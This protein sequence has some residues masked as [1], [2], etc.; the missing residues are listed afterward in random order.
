VNME[1][2]ELERLTKKT[3]E[4]IAREIQQLGGW[5]W[6]ALIEP[7]PHGGGALSTGRVFSLDGQE[8]VFLRRIREEL[9]PRIDDLVA[10]RYWDESLGA[11]DFSLRRTEEGGWSFV[12]TPEGPPKSMDNDLWRI[13]VGLAWALHGRPSDCVKR[14][15]LC[16]RRFL[17]R[18]RKTKLYCSHR[19]AVKAVDARRQE[20]E[21]RKEKQRE[22]QLR[23]YQRKLARQW[24][25]DLHRV[26]WKYAKNQERRIWSLKKDPVK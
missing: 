8:K 17:Q 18:T 14:C 16:N 12:M 5:V 2:E 23:A 15:G 3:A 25:V 19:C 22:A 21:K 26:G 4:K 13:L 24:N 9:W 20:N 7:G 10:G 6:D 11:V 1:A